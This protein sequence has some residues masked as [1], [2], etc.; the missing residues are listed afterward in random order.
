MRVSL[1]LEG[2]NS[3]IVK[4]V[5]SVHLSIASANLHFCCR[6]KNVVRGPPLM[7]PIRGGTD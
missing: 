7:L 2:G 4:L 3:H 6:K 1:S 5:S